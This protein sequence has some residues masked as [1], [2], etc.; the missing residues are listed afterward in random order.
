M[1]ICDGYKATHLLRH[2]I[3]YKA[4]IHD[5]PIV[6]MTASAI[7]GD[8]EKCRRAG[9][10]D[11]LAKPVR[12]KTLEQMLVHWAVHK[13]R[14]SP[15]PTPGPSAT[16]SSDDCSDS[17]SIDC[18]NSG[19]PCVGID[20]LDDLNATADAAA[21]NEEQLPTP[22]ARFSDGVPA[23]ADPAASSDSDVDQDDEH[24]SLPTPR[25]ATLL[26]RPPMP[27][28]HRSMSTVAARSSFFDHHETQPSTPSPPPHQQHQQQQIRRVETDERAQQSRDDK[29][30]GAADGAGGQGS[31]GVTPLV[32]TS[33]G[34]GGEALTEANVEKFTQQERMRRMS[35][36]S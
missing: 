28:M 3:P 27:M 15:A 30:L 20:D 17:S 1:P 31:A 14:E 5:V 8:Q 24:S 16:S 6:A 21:A 11:Y 26:R 10:D 35:H 29:L 25:P 32:H 18:A 23:A 9:M 19:I 36:G 4:Y 12:S 22:M 7:Q 33:M 13:R 34:K 2:H